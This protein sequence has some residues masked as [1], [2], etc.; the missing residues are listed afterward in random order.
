MSLNMKWWKE[1]QKTWPVKLTKEVWYDWEVHIYSASTTVN[2]GHDTKHA[3]MIILQGFWRS[4][5]KHSTKQGMQWCANT[6]HI[7]LLKSKSTV[8][9]IFLECNSRKSVRCKISLFLQKE[10]TLYQSYIYIQQQKITDS[11]PRSIHINFRRE[12]M[13]WKNY[14]MG[15]CI[16]PWHKSAILFNKWSILITAWPQCITTLCHNLLQLD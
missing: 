10:H 13:W 12:K 2:L 6:V 1:Q 9:L 8:V 14:G 3:W 4:R 11:G 5:D 7:K 16:L 15:Y